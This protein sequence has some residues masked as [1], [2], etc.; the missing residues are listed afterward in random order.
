MNNVLISVKP[1]Y[2]YRM[3]S[4]E[5]SIEIRRRYIKIPDGTLL[6]VYATLPL[7]CIL[8]VAVVECSMFDKPHK[9]WSRYAS[10]IGVEA[11]EFAAYVK[12]CDKISAIKIN[13]ISKIEPSIP[14]S[15]LKSKIKGFHPPQFMTRLHKDN[16]LLHYLMNNTYHYNINFKNRINKFTAVR[17]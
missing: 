16:S 9:I 13:S 4:G 12:N 11:E 15:M 14:L 10:Q 2:V 7:G 3:L 8:A 6:W 1:K 5:K 17:T